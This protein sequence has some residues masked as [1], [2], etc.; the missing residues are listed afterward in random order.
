MDKKLELE[1]SNHVV[2]DNQSVLFFKDV[3]KKRNT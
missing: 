3:I 2:V 1:A